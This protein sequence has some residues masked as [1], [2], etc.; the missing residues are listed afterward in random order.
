MSY[1]DP[2]Y[3]TGAGN[4][5]G[6]YP[7]A[8]HNQNTYN[9]NNIHYN[10]YTRPSHPTYDQSGYDTGVQ[11][12]AGYNDDLSQGPQRTP[13]HKSNSGTLHQRQDTYPPASTFPATP[14]KKTASAM[15]RYRYDQR[16]G[17]WTKGGRARC[18]GRFFFCTLVTTVFLVV[19]IILAFLLWVRPPALT[20]GNIEPVPQGGS[21]FTTSTDPE[22]GISLKI[23]VQLNITIDNPNT[24][25][26]DLKKV[27]AKLTYPINDVPIGGGNATNI[28][29]PAHT[30]TEWLFPFDIL[31]RSSKDPG[32]AVLSD[33]L[34][35]CTAKENL[36]INYEITPDVGILFVSASPTISNTLSLP[37]PVDPKDL[38]GLLGGAGGI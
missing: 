1:Q 27:D 8:G 21:L 4:Q 38:A 36:N 24:F 6:T 2:Y 13:T 31:Y 19:S 15:R 12:S 5:Y 33:L 3:N 29:F 20:I 22:G 35:K 11:D 28:K 9:Y 10:P 30:R 17:V 32:G 18:F 37:C 16:G 26:V 25:S 34:R 7:D 23:H 14:L